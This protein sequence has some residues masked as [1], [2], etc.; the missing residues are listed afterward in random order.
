MSMI[1]VVDPTTENKED[2]LRKINEFVKLIKDKCMNLYQPYKNISIDE[3]IVKSKHRFGIR[4]YIENK[5]IKF[6][7]K[8]WVLADSRNGYTVDFNVYAGKNSKDPIHVNGLGD[9]VVIKLMAPFLNHNYHLFTDNFY[10]LCDLFND[11][12]DEGVYCCGMVTGNRKGFPEVMKME[13][14]G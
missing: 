9:H 4:Q 6:G 13:N 7:L 2:K 1:H 8:L 14:S 12:F 10:N 11:L 5:P 3:R